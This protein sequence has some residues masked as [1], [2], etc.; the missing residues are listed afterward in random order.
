M[1][2]CDDQVFDTQGTSARLVWTGRA[3]DGSCIVV[4]ADRS[5][6][7]EVERRWPP[8]GLAV[9]D[10][11]RP[12]IVEP[13]V[14]SVVEVHVDGGSVEV[15]VDGRS[16]LGGWDRL[17]S[18]LGLFAAERLVGRVAV[19]A[20]VI[21]TEAGALV[22]PGVSGAGKTTLCTAARTAGLRVLSDEFALVDTSTLLVAGWSRPM[23][24]RTPDGPVRVALP[25]GLS[26]PI[27][28][29]LV[30][31]VVHDPHGPGLRR[32]DESEVVVG[33]LANTVCARRQPEASFATAVALARLAAG[34]GG[35]RGEAAEALDE[36]CR[37]ACG[38]Q[39]S[40][41][42]PGRA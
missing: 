19:H 41:D 14:E 12:T 25:E 30:A 39:A 21:E 9:V 42:G 10:T 34:V 3:E 2:D 7:A 18:E 11:S 33:L 26:S 13:A 32:L 6:A 17:E 22:V 5:A 36:L 15:F 27:R 23:R 4:H 37:L 16:A 38:N 28:V 8:V 40:P 29:A 20:A 35:T 1:D 31:L 24:V